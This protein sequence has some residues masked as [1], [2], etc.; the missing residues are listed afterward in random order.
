MVH[1]IRKAMQRHRRFR[2]AA[3]TFTVG[4]RTFVE[5]SHPFAIACRRHLRI[6]G[7]A[8]AQDLRS[9]F[10]DKNLP[11]I[12]QRFHMMQV[13]M[14][15]ENDEAIQAVARERAANFDDHRPQG[16]RLQR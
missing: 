16:I 9:I 4:L 1:Q 5:L 14:A 15:V 10:F 13:A 7:K 11:C 3:M 12:F 6:A 2:L 8:D